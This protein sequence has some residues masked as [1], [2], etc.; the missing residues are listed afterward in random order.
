ML[1]SPEFLFLIREILTSGQVRSLNTLLV[2][3]GDATSTFFRNLKTTE[4]KIKSAYN[5]V[6][7]NPFPVDVWTGKLKQNDL[8]RALVK[9]NKP[10]CVHLTTVGANVS[11]K[12]QCTQCHRIKGHTEDIFTCAGVFL[13]IFGEM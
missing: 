1:Y 7:W 4:E 9:M 8:L 6:N 13:G 11:G 3:R 12:V 10:V 5:V 2:A